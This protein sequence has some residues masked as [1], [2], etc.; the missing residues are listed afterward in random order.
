MARAVLFNEKCP[1]YNAG[2]RAGFPDAVADGLVAR[3]VAT[4]VVTD[5]GTAPVT[6]GGGVPAASN[7]APID[8]PQPR[9]DDNDDD[10]PEARPG[11]LER[12]A[13]KRK[14]K[15]TAT[16]KKKTTSGK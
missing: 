1:P 15:K 4:Y 12:M 8:I 3:G 9:D 16:R 13:G 10:E 2:D 11:L 5:I 6:K 7:P 14:K